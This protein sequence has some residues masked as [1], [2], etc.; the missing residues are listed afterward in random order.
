MGQVTS[1]R[2]SEREPISQ[3]YVEKQGDGKVWGHKGGAALQPIFLFLKLHV[4]SPMLCRNRGCGPVSWD[5]M[6][7]GGM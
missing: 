2:V 6:G 3:L 7:M 4:L 5:P 1:G